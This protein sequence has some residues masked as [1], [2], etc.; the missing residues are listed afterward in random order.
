MRKRNIKNGLLRVVYM[1]EALVYLYGLLGFPFVTV[2]VY[3]L[4]KHHIAP[5]IY[6]KKGYVKVYRILPNGKIEYKYAK[7]KHIKDTA[8]ELK[9]KEGVYQFLDI[10]DYYFFE[11]NLKCVL[12]DQEGNQVNIKEMQKL[13]PAI[14]PEMAD[15]LMQRV[16]NTAKI[17]AFKKADRMEILMWII[18]IVC[19]LTFLASAVTSF[20]VSDIHQQLL[21][22]KAGIKTASTLTPA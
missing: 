12:Y 13:M 7:P 21:L 1:N 18:L 14:S 20:K 3:F 8:H 10:P 22:L 16:W 6:S 5:W 2:G 19:G 15:I 17:A 9:L 4:F 11:K